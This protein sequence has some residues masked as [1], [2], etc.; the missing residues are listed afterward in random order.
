MTTRTLTSNAKPNAVVKQLSK[1]GPTEGVQL[2]NKK[3]TSNARSNTVLKSWLRK[4]LSTGGLTLT[5][6]S[7]CKREVKH[8]GQNMAEVHRRLNKDRQQ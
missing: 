8:S 2:A 1:S 7:D 3:V 4:A 6:K 5:T